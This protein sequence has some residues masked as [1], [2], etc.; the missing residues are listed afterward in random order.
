MKIYAYVE[1]GMGKAECQDRV[2]IGDT[3]LAGGFLETEY[4]KDGNFLVAVA[5][6][7]GGYKGGERA[8]LMVV[9]SIRVLNRRANLVEDDIKELMKRINMQLVKTGQM[10]PAYSSMA[11]TLTALV[12]NEEKA[13]SIHIGNCRMYSHRRYLKFI[14]KDHTRVAELVSRGEMTEEE[15]G[16]SPIRN[17]INGCFGGNR[18]ELFHKLQVEVQKEIMEQENNLVL[19]CD[20]IHDYI[21]EDEM[22]KI[23][24]EETTAYGV[25]KKMASLAREHGSEDDISIIII[26]RL[27]KYQN[28]ET[29]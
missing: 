27:K 9:D 8:S 15:A 12:M 3:I 21:N 19:T 10:Y 23:L 2:L 6:G 28:F 14:T 17:Q 26:D 22:E 7:V 25:C 24:E 16:V 20:G 11:T 29:L 18:E 4:E 5:D 1:K 13:I